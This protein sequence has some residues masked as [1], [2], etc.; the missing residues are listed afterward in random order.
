MAG[1]LPKGETTERC[2]G[3]AACMGERQ[4]CLRTRGQSALSLFVYL[5]LLVV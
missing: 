5:L 3:M 4:T 1:Q 2:S